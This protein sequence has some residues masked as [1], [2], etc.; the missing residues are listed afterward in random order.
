MPGIITRHFRQ[1]NAIQFAESF[2]ESAPTRYYYYIAKNTSYA[3]TIQITGTVKY[4]SG[5]NTVVGQGTLFT[6][7]LSVG[8]R[9]GVTGLATQL[10]VHSIS[11]SQTFI[12]AIRPAT[13][14]TAGANAYIRK[15]FS[16]SN[17]PT[18]TDS[19]QDTYYDIWR[20][21]ISLKKIQASDVSYVI[22]RYNWSNNTFYTQYTD[23][24]DT[25][26]NAVFYVI[27]NEYNVYKCIDNNRGANST[28][29][30]T[31]TSTSIIS[32]ADNYRWKYMYTVSGANVVKFLNNDW[33]PVQTLS[34]NN[35]TAQWT[36]QQN[37]AN[38]AIHHI[39]VVAN[40]KNYLSTTNTFVA[41]SNSTTLKLSPSA[42]S[43]NDIYN[44]SGIF[45]SSG[46]GAGQLRKIVNY[47]GSNNTITVNSA[48][49]TVPN[50][51]SRYIISPLVTVRGDSGGTAN[52]RCTAY[53]SNTFGGQVRKITV[54]STGRSYSTANVTITANVGTGA[55]AK[56]VISPL[57]GHGSDAVDELF[58]DNVML[59]LRIAGN[60]SN[61]FPTNNDFRVIGVLRDP[62]L[63]NGFAANSSVIDQTTR[64][65]INA[66]TGDFTTDEVII[67]QTSGAKARL[68]YFANTNAAKT[69]GVLKITNVV[70]NGTGG[71]FQ[72]GETLQGETSTV[73]ANVVS[74]TK[75]A[76]KPYSGLIIYNENRTS[77]V[78]AEDQTENVKIIVRF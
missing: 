64:I 57:N 25:L 12:T 1:H 63:A 34:S 48:F 3:N 18:P 61:T 39:Y 59:D 2:S 67:G 65:T 74:V 68:V 22:P 9:I 20:G 45:I 51:S 70:R 50:T 69:Q 7:E 30:P 41:V 19:Y 44:G 78:R 72:P 4:N 11:T 40:G 55:T 16:D 71:N 8:D 58:G 43:V 38:G 6:T 33:I 47:A 29:K 53:V 23:T 66:S 52:S 28:V 27:T 75:P 54:I 76:L 17:P 13:S 24:N 31:G 36:V 62:L 49:T 10:R 42:S 37:A 5:S 21:M 26:A 77:V 73:S 60:E 32:T 46:L 35:G 56:A 15:Q 14:N